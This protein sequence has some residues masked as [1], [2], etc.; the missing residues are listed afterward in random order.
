MN[1]SLR[2]V[3]SDFKGTSATADEK[4]LDKQFRLIA[5][6]LICY[7][8]LEI[9]SGQ[10]SKKIFIDDLEFYYHEEN[11]NGI[12]DPIIYHRNHP[13]YKKPKTEDY[14]FEIGELNLHQ[15]GIDITFEN[16]AMQYR[17]SALIRG[18][19]MEEDGDTI[20]YSTHIY[21]DLF[22]GMSV[23]DGITIK[24]VD[25]NAHVKRQL[26]EKTFTRQNVMRYDG[27]VKT[28]NKCSRLWRYKLKA[29]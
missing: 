24:W 13:E 18:Y 12:K 7:G 19:R 6:Y 17:A 26:E 28:K 16:K 10:K 15:S 29:Q 27:Y 8:Y 21:D 20:P 1:D 9:T 11:E 5:Q 23:L 3:L 22:R 25:C 14:Y 2:T 4:L